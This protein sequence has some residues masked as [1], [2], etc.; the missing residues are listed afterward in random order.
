MT[1]RTSI[2]D[3]CEKTGIELLVLFGSAA[4]GT[5]REGSDIDLA[6]KMKTDREIDKLDLIFHLGGIFG[7]REIDLVVLTLDTDP[8]LLFEIFS[9]G[10]PLYEAQQGIF[11]N[12]QLRAFKLY[13]DTEKIR[14]FQS[15]YLRKFAAGARNVA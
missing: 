15:E 14:R 6:V 7:D 4:K 12:D 1:N 5:E 3:F 13:Y 2:K 8:V 9:Q 10:K 11:E